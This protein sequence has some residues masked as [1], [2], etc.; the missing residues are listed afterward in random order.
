[1][2]LAE[3]LEVKVKIILP[4]IYNPVS[5]LEFYQFCYIRN[6]KMMSNDSDM[7]SVRGEVG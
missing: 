3:K 4:S 7:Q 2:A 1:M 6:M 5:I